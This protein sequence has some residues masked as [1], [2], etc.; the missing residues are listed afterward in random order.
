MRT[1][2]GTRQQWGLVARAARAPS[3]VNGVLRA[4]GAWRGVRARHPWLPWRPRS[5]RVRPDG[6]RS[7]SNRIGTMRPIPR[8]PWCPGCRPS[9]R[10]GCVQGAIAAPARQLAGSDCRRGAALSPRCRCQAGRAGRAGG[11]RPLLLVTSQRPLAWR[12]APLARHGPAGY[13]PAGFRPAHNGDCSQG[14]LAERVVQGD[15]GREQSRRATFGRPAGRGGKT[16]SRSRQAP[17]TASAPP[18]VVRPV[19]SRAIKGV[20]ARV[21]RSCRDVD[22]DLVSGHSGHCRPD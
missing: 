4:R 1:M 18:L 16:P 20:R 14:L 5:C 15:M 17:L 12:S 13:H 21:N 3:R 9:P 19:S 7:R 6:R 11:V 10:S 2:R 8:A 22:A